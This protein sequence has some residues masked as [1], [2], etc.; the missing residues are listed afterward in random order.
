[1]LEDLS[2]TN[3]KNNWYDII[4]D[5]AVFHVFSNEDR[6][7]YIKN[8]EYLIKVGGLYIELCFSEKET[9]EG[10]LRRIKKS[11]LNEFLFSIKWLEN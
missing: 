7:G 9:C 4:L 8:V 10:G 5:A 1:M 6:Q 2:T 3:S 11:L